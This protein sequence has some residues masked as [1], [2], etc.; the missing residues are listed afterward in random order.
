MLISEYKVKTE[1][2]RI[3]DGKEIP[4]HRH[5]T[6]YDMSCDSCN[7]YFTEHR[8]ISYM[9]KNRMHLCPGCRKNNIGPIRQKINRSKENPEK[10]GTIRLHKNSRYKEIYVGIDSWHTKSQGHWCR[11]HIYVIEEEL[12]HTIPL[13]YVVHH[14]D[15]DKVNN[16]RS[17]L[18]LMTVEEHNN[19]HA[20][21]EALV[22]ELVKSGLIVFNQSTK[23]YEF[24]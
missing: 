15:G 5:K 4:Y 18:C 10:I 6:M 23:L 1:Y 11:E 7:T 3:R 9:K 22:F 19:T 13:G 2:V 17:N 14:I 12:G 8:D 24:K 21:S 16:N 20:K